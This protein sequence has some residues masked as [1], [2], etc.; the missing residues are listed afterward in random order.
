MNSQTKTCQNCH[1]EFTIEPDDFAFYEKIK[2]PPP[3]L[4]P[5]CRYQR[6]GANRNEWSFYKR[7]CSLC[8]KSMVSI[9]NSSYPGPVYCQQCWWSDKWEPLE[10][11]RDFDFSKPFFEQFSKLRFETPR[12]TLANAKSINSEYSNQSEENKNCYMVVASG[13]SENC[14]YG[15]WY[16]GSKDCM[17]SWSMIDCEIMYESLNGRGSYK[18]FFVDDC[19]ESNDIYF[20]KDCRRCN[21]CFGCIGLRGKSYCWFNEQITKEEF[22]KRLSEASW[23]YEDVQKMKKRIEEFWLKFPRK[24][25][26]GTKSVNTT[27]ENISSNKNVRYGFNVRRS[28]NL[29]YAQDAWEARD[30]RDLTETLDN[31]LEYELEGCGWGNGGISSAKSWWNNDDLYSDLNFNCNNIFGCVS[32]HAKSYCI[33]NKQYSKE[34]YHTLKEKIIEHMRKTKE[35]GEFFPITISP[36]P[37]NDTIAQDYFP[38]IKDE[39]I[40]RGWKWFDRDARDYKVT[41]SH[42]NLPAKISDATD[43]ILQEIISCS[44]QDSETE[45]ASHLR[46]AT[47]FRLHPEELQFYRRFNLPIP[48]KCSAC[49]LQERLA[50]RNPRKLW[51]RQCMCNKQHAHHSGRCPSEFETSYAPDRKEIIYCEQC[52]NAEVA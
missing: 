10:Y 12:I 37:Y 40:S 50:R 28:E 21:S 30:C 4:C 2:V 43:S 36:F 5:D 26:Q 42:E 15:N 41:L 7:N 3:T 20:S 1:N 9:Y 25:C 52:Y 18:C 14:M 47:A 32:L 49:R 24:Y 34:E 19:V 6:R 46:C 11:G 8:G 35:W 39:V 51:H 48:H 45:K 23:A 44:S 29:S 17:D 27:G 13:S 38:L 33:F 31:E 16:Q 22:Q